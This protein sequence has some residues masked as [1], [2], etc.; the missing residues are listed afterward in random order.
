M[1]R[2]G[3]IA[4]NQG[5]HARAGVLWMEARPLFERSLQ[6][7]DVAQVDARLLD[8]EIGRYDGS[9]NTLPVV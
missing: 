4:K 1:L 3:D 2:L 5:D 9:E 7:N 6:G 8:I